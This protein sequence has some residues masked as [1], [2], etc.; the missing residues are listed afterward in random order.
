MFVFREQE[1]QN[2]VYL[3]LFPNDPE[4][5]KQ[6]KEPPYKTQ[7]EPP[8][9]SRLYT[10]VLLAVHGVEKPSNEITKLLRNMLEKKLNARILQEIQDVL[11][12]VSFFVPIKFYH[13]FRM[14]KPVWRSQMLVSFNKT[15]RRLPTFSTTHFRQP[16]TSYCSL[17]STILNNKLYSSALNR[18]S[19]N[20]VAPQLTVRVRRHRKGTL[21]DL[22]IRP[23]CNRGELFR[24]IFV[25]YSI[26]SSSTSIHTEQAFFSYQASG[27]P[28]NPS[29]YLPM[30]F[31]LNRPPTEG[32]RD[33]GLACIEVI[34]T[35]F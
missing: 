9:D 26:F 23:S 14:L 21:Q 29:G 31:L 27:A 1:T 30:F 11:A 34:L 18:W 7:P 28:E 17:W 19:E 8:P 24:N 10:H 3:C 15:F 12:K 20:R 6:F 16:F 5:L 2:V 4:I 13:V 35:Q 22:L 25:C 32:R 33:I